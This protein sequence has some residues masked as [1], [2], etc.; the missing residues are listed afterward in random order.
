[1]R[2]LFALL[3]LLLGSYE[4]RANDDV[5]IEIDEREPRETRHVRDGMLAEL[6]ENAVQ[7][8]LDEDWDRC[9]SAFNDALYG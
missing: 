8:Y 4:Y 1:M 5:P 3:V 6:L 7:A 2:R 9:I